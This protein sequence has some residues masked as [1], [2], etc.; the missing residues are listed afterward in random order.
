MIGLQR[1]MGG[2]YAGYPPPLFWEMC[3]IER[4]FRTSSPSM[5]CQGNPAQTGDRGVSFGQRGEGYTGHP[6]TLRAGG[7]DHVQ[8]K[9]GE[10]CQLTPRMGG[11]CVGPDMC[12]ALSLQNSKMPMD[13]NPKKD[14]YLCGIISPQNIP[15]RHLRGES[16][17]TPCPGERREI[18]LHPR[19]RRVWTG[20]AV[21]TGSIPGR[22]YTSAGFSFPVID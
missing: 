17:R 7:Y 10:G 22:A 9:L 15:V 19:C 21:T 11:I 4:Y 8:T 20:M 14:G 5:N 3:I 13:N 18:C 2:R 12:V 6:P 16:C 1:T